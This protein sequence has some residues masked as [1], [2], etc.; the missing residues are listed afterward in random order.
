MQR[1]CK[2]FITFL[3]CLSIGLTAFSQVKEEYKDVLL[4]GKP[5]RLNTVT[6]EITLITAEDNGENP[7]LD[8]KT[9]APSLVTNTAV[10]N[11]SA[12][13]SSE[14]TESD[15]HTVKKGETLLDLSKTYKV[16]LTALKR[17]NNLETT[18]INEG[19]K[20]KVKNLELPTEPMLGNNDEAMVM[21]SDFHIVEKGNTLYSLSKQYGL[22]VTELKQLNDL[23]SNLIKV[24]QK[25]KVKGVP[26]SPQNDNKI[27]YTVKKGDNLFRIALN[28]GTTVE[29]LKKLNGLTGNTI[30]IGQILRLK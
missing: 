7:T 4:D 20:L 19:Q 25:L 16:S 28:N 11:A 29:A 5:A 13:T 18:L 6:G 2:L 8:S 15:Y 26:S 27:T 1:N 14:G 10:I 24:G 12:D 30:K 23:D 9:E 17:A 22:S 21:S 3:C